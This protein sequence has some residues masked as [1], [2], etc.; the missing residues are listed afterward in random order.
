MALELGVELGIGCVP[1]MAVCP[2]PGTGVCVDSTDKA[3]Q[4][5]PCQY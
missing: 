1:G 3:F 5:W 2:R 4:I